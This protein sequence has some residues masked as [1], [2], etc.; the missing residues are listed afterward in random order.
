MLQDQVPG[1]AGQADRDEVC[2]LC[3]RVGG[4]G[5]AYP[6]HETDVSIRAEIQ[7][8]GVLPNNPN[9]ARISELLA[10]LDHWVGQM[11]PGSYGSDELLFWLMAKLPRELWDECWSTA[12]GKARALNHEY[13]SVLLLER[14]LDKERDQHLKAY[15]PGEGASGS[16]GGRYQ[17]TTPKNTRIM[18][19]VQD[20]SGGMPETSRVP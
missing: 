1:E 5:A 8:L 6:T 7:I 2:H 10:D 15:R 13:L 4:F 16:R 3:R 11:M 18:S 19:N 9:P 14:A 17:G 20:S 12:E